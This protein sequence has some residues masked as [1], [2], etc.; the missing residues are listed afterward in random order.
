MSEAGRAVLANFSE[1]SAQDQREV[2][3]E[4]V[5]RASDGG[6]LTEAALDEV[7]SELFQSYDTEE[8]VLG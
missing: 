6:E 7:A 2:V 5:R 4:L 8:A 1:L 3:A